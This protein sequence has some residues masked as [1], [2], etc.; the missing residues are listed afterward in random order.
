MANNRGIIKSLFA[1]SLLLVGCDKEDGRANPAAS[2]QGPQASTP[3]TA[4]PASVTG[5]GA[6]R[7]V[8]KFEGP[9]PP[10]KP[11]VQGDCHTGKGMTAMPDETVVIGAGGELKNAIVFLKNP[12]PGNGGPGATQDPLVDQKECLYIPHVVA[13]KVGRQVRFTSSDAILHNVHALGKNEMNVPVQ[14]GSTVVLPAAEAG[15]NK[16]KCD[17]H[18]WMSCWV[19]VFDH[20]YFVVT[21]DDG[22]FEI[23]GLGAGKY[24]VVVWQERLG[25]REQEITIGADEMSADVT[26]TVTAKKP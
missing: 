4:A 22:K 19:G 20:G 7:G 14:Q 5:K 10:A 25:Q 13:A 6:I 11:P 9:R 16:V 24:T 12:P 3:T 8:V 26:L 15:F 18:P 17:V 23:G 21:G 1:A 2:K